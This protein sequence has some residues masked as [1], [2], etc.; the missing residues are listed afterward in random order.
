MD[1]MTIL[2]AVLSS[3]RAC[4]STYSGFIHLYHNVH[5]LKTDKRETAVHYKNYIPFVRC[6][7]QYIQLDGTLVL[8]SQSEKVMQ[9]N[10]TSVS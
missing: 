4:L 2:I 7:S 3:V 1:L 10:A 6:I 5:V 9:I 8:T